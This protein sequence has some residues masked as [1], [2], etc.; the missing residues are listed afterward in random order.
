VEALVSVYDGDA[1][2]AELDILKALSFTIHRLSADHDDVHRIR[3]PRY[4]WW[5]RRMLKTYQGVCMENPQLAV[6]SVENWDEL[7]EVPDKGVIAARAHKNWLVRLVAT[8]VCVKNGFT[9]IIAPGD[10]C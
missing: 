6:T 9:L 7:I 10:P 1:W 3:F 4:K 2:V 5:D 8:V